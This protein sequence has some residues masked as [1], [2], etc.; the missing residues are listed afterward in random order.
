MRS[1]VHALLS[2]STSMISASSGTSKLTVP[3]ALHLG[4]R[5]ALNASSR[6]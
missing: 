4:D 3:L 1:E 6:A 5:V 2:Y